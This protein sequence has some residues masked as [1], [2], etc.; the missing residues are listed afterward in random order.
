M[1]NLSSWPI[2]P[3]IGTENNPLGSNSFLED[4]KI[5]SEVTSFIVLVISD[6]SI[7]G[8]IFNSSWFIGF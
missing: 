3:K 1:F 7:N 8:S 5:A 2:A 4:W 6:L